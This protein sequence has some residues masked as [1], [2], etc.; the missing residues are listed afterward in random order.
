MGTLTWSHVD[1][2]LITLRGTPES[3]LAEC[4]RPIQRQHL[5]ASYRAG[6]EVC[7][8]PGSEL[9][10]GYYAFYSRIFDERQW[11]PPKLPRS[12]FHD[13]AGKWADAAE[14]VVMKHEGRVVGGGI[15]L[16]DMFALNLY[17]AVTDRNVKGVYPH[18]V[19]YQLAIERAASRGLHYVNLGFNPGSPGLIRFKQ[20]WGAEPT[21]MPMLKWRGGWREMARNVRTRLGS[22]TGGV[23]VGQALETNVQIPQEIS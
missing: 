1:V 7:W 16:Y 6:L 3:H 20:S 22:L 23:D 4:V 2:F 19:L 9:V 18:P 14:M 17:H 13:V 10:D 8:Q 11:L 15:F 12:F 21:P 5:R